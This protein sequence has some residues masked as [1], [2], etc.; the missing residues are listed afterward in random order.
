MPRY[1]PLP[2]SKEPG[3]QNVTITAP[4]GQMD[5]S[6]FAPT[7][8]TG[9]A[10]ASKEW[11]AVG[12]SS[13]GPHLTM[14]NSSNL[15][16]QL[17]FEHEKI[18]SENNG[19]SQMTNAAQTQ[20]LQDW[21]DAAPHVRISTILD[22][23]PRNSTIGPEFSAIAAGTYDGDLQDL[24]QN[25]V[26]TGQDDAVLRL[27]HEFDLHS[28]WYSDADWHDAWRRV[29]D[30]MKNVAP[31]LEFQYDFDG[32]GHNE[33][34]FMGQRIIDYA[35]PG[36]QYVD[37]I[38][39]GLYDRQSWPGILGRL[40]VSRDFAIDHGVPLDWAEYGLWVSSQGGNGDNPDFIQ[41]GHDYW[42]NDMPDANRG[43]ILYFNTAANNRSQLFDPSDPGNS[44]ASQWPNSHALFM[45]L[46]TE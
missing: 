17:L 45:T 12:F 39:I 19:F 9:G 34:T 43:F 22:L 6:S 24:A 40:N 7:I 15:N 36:D 11:M 18:A 41:N 30:Q 28:D 14:E 29:H 23:F 13:T 25:F 42:I 31:N 33:T 46:F 20:K 1:I 3:Q 4:L 16:R 27:W 10:P 32:P 2:Q 38:G 35:W 8:D 37:R 21:T 44:S 26:D 5:F